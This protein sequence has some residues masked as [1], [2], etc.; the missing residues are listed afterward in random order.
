MLSL[1]RY[2]HL[3]P[4]FVR[5]VKNMEVKDRIK[6]LRSYVWSSY[7]SYAGRSKELEFVEYGPVLAQV[8]GRSRKD[9]KRRFREYVEA[10]IAETDKEFE[11]ALKESRHAIGG[12]EFIRKID[13]LYESL[14]V[15]KVVEDVS[16]RRIIEPLA[17]ES[18]IEVITAITGE[19]R[20]DIVR[21][22]R[23]TR[24]RAITARMLTKYGGLT[25]RE[26]A[27]L[28]NVGSG[29]AISGLLSRLTESRSEDKKLDRLMAL[30]EKALEKKRKQEKEPL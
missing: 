2:V 4:V 6:H 22:R 11:K 8:K 19:E 23:G 13:D 10:G 18:V 21:R 20:S 15:K 27:G 29:A 7:N 12:A 3:N 17:P 1:A 24:V 5:T 28:L 30:I 14:V 25:Q 9:A 26:V 16:F